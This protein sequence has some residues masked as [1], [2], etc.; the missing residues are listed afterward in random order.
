MLAIAKVFNTG[1]SQAVRIP[2]EFR[3]EGSDLIINR[4]G[5]TT[6]LN[7]KSDPWA[8]LKLV[9]GKATKDFMS[10]RIQGTVEERK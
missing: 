1:R 2:K 9:A 8:T 6:M 10:E 3:F 4:I 5:K 7:A